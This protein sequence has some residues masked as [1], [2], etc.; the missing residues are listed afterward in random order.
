MKLT[1]FTLAATLLMTTFASAQSQV[2]S[3][4]SQLAAQGYTVTNVTRSGNQYTVTSQGNGK[5]RNVTFNAASG[6]VLSDD[7]NRSSNGG[8]YVE[9]DDNGRNHDNERDDDYGRGHESDDGGRGESDHSGRDDSDRGG[10]DSDH[11]SGGDSDHGESD[12]DGGDDHD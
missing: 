7:S 9:N 1:T 10:N 12:H 6:E 2:E 4:R 5:Q 8:H 11:S 3:V